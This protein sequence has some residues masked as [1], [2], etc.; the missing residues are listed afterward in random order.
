MPDAYGQL[1]L[2]DDVLETHIAWD[3]GAGPLTIKLARMLDAPG[4]LCGF[5][6]LLIDPNRSRDRADLILETSDMIPVPGN[7][8]LEVEERHHRIANFFDPYHERLDYEFELACANG[9]RPFV[10][11][12][13]TFTRRLMGD[14]QDRPWHIGILWRDDEKSA[15]RIIA[16]LR[17]ETN[18]LIGDNEPYDARVFNYSIDRHVAARHLRHVTFEV[19]QDLVCDEEGVETMASILASALDKIVQEG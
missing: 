11:A 4:L 9:D 18:Y 14:A 8:N 6:R 16:L 5:S 3:V 17:R 2:P 12:V 13:H 10:V 19:R 1:G 15:K 7:Q